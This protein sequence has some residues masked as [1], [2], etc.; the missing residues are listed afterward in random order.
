MIL[1]PSDP[2]YEAVMADQAEENQCTILPDA[3]RSKIYCLSSQQDTWITDWDN[4]YIE[5]TND[6]ADDDLV[7]DEDGFASSL[8]EYNETYL[9]D[10]I[11]PDDCIG[12]LGPLNIQII[13]PD[14]SDGWIGPWINPSEEQ[15]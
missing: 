8:I 4:H 12:T 3:F 6:Y 9:N 15:P 7:A 10:A 11:Y 5:S 2:L 1:L 14:Q 13:P